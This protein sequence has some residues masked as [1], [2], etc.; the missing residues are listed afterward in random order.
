MQNLEFCANVAFFRPPASGK[1]PPA[2]RIRVMVAASPLGG[3]GSIVCANLLAISKT[4]DTL[5]QKHKLKHLKN[6]N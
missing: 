5:Y 4:S 2:P 3:Q 6:I 1:P